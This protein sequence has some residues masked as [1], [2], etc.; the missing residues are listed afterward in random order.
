MASTAQ[1]REHVSTG[2]MRQRVGSGEWE[3]RGPGVVAVAGP[4]TWTRRIRSAQLAA[5]DDAAISHGTAA[6]LHRFDGFDR[7]EPVHITTCLGIHRTSFLDVRVHRSAL[8]ALDACDRIDGMLVVSRPVALL[9]VAGAHGRTAAAR[10]LDGM[11]RNGDSPIWID[12]VVTAWRRRG[13]KGPAV[14][15]DLLAERVERRLPASWFQRLTSRVLRA[16]GIE[17]VDEYTVHDLDGKV[18]A[19]LDL[20]LP[21][22]RVGV[23]CQSWQ[24][25]G[26][27][28]AQAADA[29]RRRR[30]RVLGW[31]IVDVWWSDLGRADEIAEELVY[32]ITRRSN[33]RP[34]P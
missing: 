1:L 21:G 13:V 2:L 6:R 5:G 30:L 25:H 28:T 27:P 15:L 3:R 31:E 14:V 11:L 33:P 24:W 19:H 4:D 34:L 8:L 23:E 18:L 29:R 16:R 20:A 7:F 10:A 22:L 17:M 26:T 9:Q 32:L 12:E